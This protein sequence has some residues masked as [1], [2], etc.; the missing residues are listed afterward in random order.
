MV[1]AKHFF[2]LDSLTKTNMKDIMID[3]DENSSPLLS[4][5]KNIFD[6]LMIK[7][8]PEK[9]HKRNKLNKLNELPARLSEKKSR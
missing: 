9:H 8:I 5:N 1:G 2:R 7:K 6:I 3:I 4:T